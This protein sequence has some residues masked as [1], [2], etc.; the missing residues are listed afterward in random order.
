MRNR[1]TNALLTRLL[2]LV[3]LAW[4]SLVSSWS[5]AETLVVGLSADY[6]PLVFRRDGELVGIEPDNAK[7]VASLLG[8]KL[9]LVEMPFEQLLPALQAG[10]VDVLMSGLSITEQRRSKVVFVTPFMRVGQMAIIRSSDVARFGYP[11][12]IYGPG[13]RV[14]VEPLTTGA[15][16][17]RDSMAEAVVHDYTRPEDAFTALREKKI[18]VYIHDAPTSWKLANSREYN[19]LFSLY[20]LLTQEELAWAVAKHNDTLL[21]RLERARTE[22]EQSGKLRAIQDFWIPV[23]IEVN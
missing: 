10:K 22:L 18:D 4:L 11:R 8:M 7:E 23:K 15:K 17:V 12:A 3:A 9:R 19:D 2:S 5:L 21:A 16:F 13:V 6:E 20:R 14:G 1:K